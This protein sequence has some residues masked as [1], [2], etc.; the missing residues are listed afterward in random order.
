MNI[1]GKEIIAESAGVRIVRFE[2]EA[3]LIAKKAKPGQFVVLMVQEAGERFPL[4][5]VDADSKRGL[6]TLIVQEAG[7]STR[8][9]GSLSQGDSIYALVGPLGHATAI[10]DYGKVIIVGGGVGIAEIYS[11]AKAFKGAGNHITT[12]IGS[13]TK[14]LLIL[15]RE[16]KVVSDELHAA[17][18][19]GTYG[20]QGFVTD[21][22]KK[23]LSDSR[24]PASGT[25]VYTVGPIP[26]MRAVAAVTRPYKLKTVASLNALMVDGTGM[27]GSCRV[28][29]NGELRFACVDGPE[30][31]AQAV[32]WDEFSKRSRIYENKEKHICKLNQEIM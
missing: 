4:T 15:E 19:D 6:I 13:R 16:L 7:L 27:C 3:P 8:L 29:V 32:D 23:I 25:L 11:V 17:T 18:D 5:I 31:D 9:L 22:L 14:D 26:M 12:I 1:I 30:F 20:I 2:I 21:I 28:S 24:P 10:A